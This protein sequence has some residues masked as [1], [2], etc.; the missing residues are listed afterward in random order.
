[1]YYRDF[2]ALAQLCNVAAGN[3][4][5]LAAAQVEQGVVNAITLIA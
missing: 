3:G 2:Y 1:L 4:D 5:D